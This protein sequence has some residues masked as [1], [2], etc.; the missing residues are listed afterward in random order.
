MK[1]VLVT[2]GETSGDE[3]AAMLVREL[4]ASGECRVLAM[5]GKKLQEAGAEVL[6]PID[7]FAFMGFFEI[8]RHLPG[9]ISL[10]GKIKR[11]LGSGDIDLF[12]PVD[13][14]GMNLKL[15]R[16]ARACGVPVLYYISPQVWA[17][18]G[19][20]TAKIAKCVDLMAVIL[21]FEE[22]FYREAG[23][24]V[25]YAGHPML[26]TIPAPKDPKSLPADG[27]TLKILILPG[28]RRQEV[29]RMLPPMLGAASL[30][31]EKIPS[32]RFTLGVAPMISL[33][34][35]TLPADLDGRID[36]SKDA[37]SEL[38]S[39]D[40]VIAASGTVTLQAAI[41][42]TPLIVV[43]KTS[44]ITFLLGKS[45]VRIPHIAMPNVLAGEKIVPELLQREVESKKIS[46]E[47]L[48]ILEDADTY[49]TMSERLLSLR[50]MLRKREG[51]KGLAARAMD[52]CR[53]QE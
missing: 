7:E 26:D 6:F 52:M 43:Y 15:A 45:L 16:H 34:E 33:D 48:A 12:I 1:T 36:I 44:P 37:V 13:Y 41:S 11:L 2:C 22:D 5:G 27:S 35:E 20:R 24:P 30:I 53:R 38:G 29:E 14:P 49:R 17:W 25:Y 10:V 42:G 31:A 3:H 4:L 21:P 51:L 46:E 47:A 8:I 50:H 39:A 32:S 28:S 40:L 23:I 18:G 9:V 19:W